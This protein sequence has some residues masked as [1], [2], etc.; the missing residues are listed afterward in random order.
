MTGVTG[1]AARGAVASGAGV[2]VLSGLASDTVLLRAY[3][4]WRRRSGDRGHG[5]RPTGQLGGEAATHPVESSR[6]PPDRVLVYRSG[7]TNHR[8][9][10]PWTAFS[11]EKTGVSYS[12]HAP[13]GLTPRDRSP[14]T[15][16]AQPY[17]SRGPGPWDRRSPRLQVG[18][19]GP[20]TFS[21]ATVPSPTSASSRD[22]IE[23]DSS[24]IWVAQA[25]ESAR[26]V[27][28]PSAKVSGVQWAATSPPTM[29]AHRP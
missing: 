28:T 3:V 21:S 5:K 29:L 13:G 22:R 14:Q 10:G 16:A 6:R 9:G 17:V 20:S 23:E 18:A 24:R 4:R 25:V 7:P 1:A 27:S 11:R 12:P 2:G 15:R 19:L 26:T 8:S